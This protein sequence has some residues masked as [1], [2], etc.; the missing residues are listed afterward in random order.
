MQKHTDNSQEIHN[1]ELILC[2]I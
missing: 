1:C 2:L